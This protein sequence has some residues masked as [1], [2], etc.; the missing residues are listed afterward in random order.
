MQQN[1]V[2]VN[3]GTHQKEIIGNMKERKMQMRAIGENINQPNGSPDSNN[4]S[5]TIS[6]YGTVSGMQRPVSRDSRIRTASNPLARADKKQNMQANNLGIN[7]QRQKVNNFFSFGG[8]NNQQN[9]QG[10]KN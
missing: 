5:N 3:M 2:I 4:F 9:T 1:Q 10:F 7:G 8:A 6:G